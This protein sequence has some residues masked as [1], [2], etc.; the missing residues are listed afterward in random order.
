VIAW[1]WWRCGRGWCS[2]EEVFRKGPGYKVAR[3]LRGRGGFCEVACYWAQA[4]AWTA[5]GGRGSIS[6]LLIRRSS[7]SKLRGSTLGT[8]EVKRASI[9]CDGEMRLSILPKSSK[10]EA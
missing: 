2:G 4:Q 9:P 3:E 8:L 10:S 6:N 5:S 7:L 1:V